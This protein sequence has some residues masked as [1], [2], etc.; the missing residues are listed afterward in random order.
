MRQCAPHG[1]YS[2]HAEDVVSFPSLRWE[3]EE[4]ALA[5]MVVKHTCDSCNS[6][7]NV[8]RKLPLTIHTRPLHNNRH[9]EQ[10]HPPHH[11]HNPKRKTRIPALT[12]TILLQPR[13]RIDILSHNRR[14]RD[15]CLAILAHIAGTEQLNGC[16]DQPGEV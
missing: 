15:I 1:L 4:S 6:F 2:V 14:A 9:D 10:P 5:I 13:Q 7:L 11:A 16:A 12:Y 8:I 3:L